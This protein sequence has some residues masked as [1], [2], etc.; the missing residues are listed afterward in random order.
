[1]QHGGERIIKYSFIF[2]YCSTCHSTQ[3]ASINGK[4]CTFDYKTKLAN[5]RWQW[6][7]ITRATQIE[8]VYVYKYNNDK[9][10]NFN[11]NLLGLDVDKR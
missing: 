9:D 5:W 6:T 11:N 7:A 4:A 1:M 2:D 8:H 10:D 3:G